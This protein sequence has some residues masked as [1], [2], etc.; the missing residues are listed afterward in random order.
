MFKRLADYARQHF[1]GTIVSAVVATAG[2]TSTAVVSLYEA[3]INRV[4]EMKVAEFNALM[5]ENA[6]F[7]ELLSAFTEE[8]ATNGV[9]DAN[10]KREL[11]SSLTRF[12]TGLGTFTANLPISKEETVR[13]LQSSVNEVKKRVQMVKAKNDLDPLS[14]A[15]VDMFQKMKLAKPVIE[16]AV[17]KPIDKEDKPA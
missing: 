3:G 9:V 13:S 2:L 14:V 6:K 8:I 1:V 12:Y 11:S 7:L 5:S 10:K 17:G 15:L 16:E 4:E